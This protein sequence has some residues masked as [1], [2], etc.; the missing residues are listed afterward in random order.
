MS[1]IIDNESVPP[2]L[3]AGIA[4]NLKKGIKSDVEDIEAEYDS[5]ET[6][7]A[8]KNA[9]ESAGIS[10]IL[11][12]ADADFINKLKKTHVDIVFNIAEGISGRGREAQIP[13]ILSFLGIP[14]SGSDETTLC[15][16][17]NKALTKR[18]LSTFGIKTPSYQLV[19]TSDFK[20][21]N[22]L[23]FPLIVKPDAEGS[24]KGISDMAIVED[25]KMLY[26]TVIKNINMY[27]EPMLMEEYITGRE[28]TVGILG[29][30]E[31]LK[32]FDPMEICYIAEARE[33][34]IY[35]Y[36]VK[37]NYKKYITYSCPPK[38]PDETIQKMKNIAAEIYKDLECRDFSRIDFMLSDNGEI[39]FIEINP[40][41]GL[42]PDYSDFPMIA[43]FCGTDYKSLV[44]N[45]LNSAL[46]RYGLNEVVT[47]RGA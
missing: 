29:N 20:L 14:Y 13:A 21:D 7:E 47:K 38:L 17:L 2:Q 45:V 11:L 28:F 5:L 32:V 24:S 12:E 39:Y 40:L 9:L 16:S 30:G 44:I 46:K 43:R 27:K 18:Y 34:R 6:I 23:N 19:K 42:T 37:K 26:E 10:V 31:D 22:S 8:I 25:E 1:E 36:N 4:Y 3:T 33:N 41:P 15:I 35:S